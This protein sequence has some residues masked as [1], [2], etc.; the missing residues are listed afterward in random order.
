MSPP[1]T[2]FNAGFRLRGAFPNWEKWIS[3]AF[4][5]RKEPTRNAI[6]KIGRIESKFFTNS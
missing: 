6:N 1:K 3:C 4:P 5:G 2:P